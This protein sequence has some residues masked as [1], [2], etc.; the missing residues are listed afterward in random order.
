MSTSWM[1]FCMLSSCPVKIVRI[2]FCLLFILSVSCEIHSPVSKSSS[3]IFSISL[4]PSVMRSFDSTSFA[5]VSV[6]S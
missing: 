1:R 6:F 3:S 4:I 5:N 2:R